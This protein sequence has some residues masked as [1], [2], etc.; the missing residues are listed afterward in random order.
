LPKGEAIAYSRSL[1]VSL[2]L[3]Q[4]CRIHI[5]SNTPNAVVYSRPNEQPPIAATQVI[6]HIAGA[7][8]GQLEH[9]HHRIDGGG[10]KANVGAGC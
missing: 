2:R 4:Q 5:D 3:P 7:E 1:R 8:G 6:D 9:S 10:Y